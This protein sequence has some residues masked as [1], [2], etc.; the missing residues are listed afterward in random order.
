MNKKK[1][2]KKKNEEEQQQEI[3]KKKKSITPDYGITVKK[4]FI[5][6]NDFLT[7][8]LKITNQLRNLL[9]KYTVKEDTMD[10]RLGGG[11]ESIY[12]FKRYLMKRVITNNIFFVRETYAFFNKDLIDTKECEINIDSQATFD[13]FITYVSTEFKHLVETLVKTATNE[14]VNV[15]MEINMKAKK[16]EEV[17]NNE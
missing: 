4:V 13:K 8:K 17:N 6:E 2:T 10:E 1:E 12:L 14:E 16:E 15:I 11:N 7:M 3:L 5:K 9:E